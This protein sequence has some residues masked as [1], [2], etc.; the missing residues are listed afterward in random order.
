[1]R[2]RCSECQRPL[3]P[4]VAIDIDGTLG[5]YHGHFIQFAEGYL[6]RALPQHEEYSGTATFWQYLGLELPLYREVKLAYRQGGMKRT[7]PRYSGSNHMT[8][9]LHEAG[10]EIWICTTRPW[11]R[12]DN[13]DPDTR[14]WC[15]RNDIY[16]DYMIYGDD[17]YQQLDMLVT[18]DRVVGVFEDLPDQ[19]GVAATLGYDPIM[20]GNYHNRYYS[21][22]EGAMVAESSWLATRALRERVLNWY[23]LHKA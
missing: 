20:K 5:D 11:L 19:I 13:V 22:P 4:V 8:H 1:M 9:N 15:R 3:K 12:L 2:T 16:Y 23:S 7:M 18:A 21:V 6:G 17:K 10:A 14:E